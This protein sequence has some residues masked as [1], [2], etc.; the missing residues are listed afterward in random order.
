[1]LEKLKDYDQWIVWKMIDGRKVP[2]NP[3]NLKGAS[4]TSQRT[5]SSFNQALRVYQESED[6]EGVGFVFSPNDPFFGIDIDKCV[7]EGGDV[8]EVARVVLTKLSGTYG[9]WSPS[10]KGLHIIGE[11]RMPDW[12]H[13]KKDPL[14]LEIYD[15]NRY[16]TITFEQL[17]ECR[18]D[19]AEAQEELDLICTKYMMKER[20]Q[21]RD[22]RV[23]TDKLPVFQEGDRD[24]K[25]F[26]T[27]RSLFHRGMDK[28]QAYAVLTELARNCQPKFD[29]DEARRKVDSAWKT[30]DP[31]PMEVVRK[32][33]SK[34]A[35]IEQSAEILVEPESEEE[36]PNLLSM[37]ALRRL[38]SPYKIRYEDSQGRLRVKNEVDYWIEHPERRCHRKIVF[39]P[40]G[41]ENERDYNLWNGFAVKPKKGD[42]STFLKHVRE[43]VSQGDEQIA[44]W[45]LDWLAA[46]VQDPGGGPKTAVVLQGGQGVGKT[47]VGEYMRKIIGDKHFQRIAHHD[48]FVGRFNY[49]LVNNIFVHLDEA[50]W[51]GD[52]KSEGML[53][54]LITD[55]KVTVEM[56]GRDRF[57]IDNNVH[58]L[59]TSNEEWP[60]PMG[61]DDRR[62]MVINMGPRYKAAG[63]DFFSELFDE[64]NNRGGPEALLYYLRYERKLKDTDPE[65]PRDVG[66][67]HRDIK[68]ASLDDVGKV[69]M[70]WVTEGR[71]GARGEWVQVVPTTELYESY[72]REAR[73]MGFRTSRTSGS[74][75][76]R[77][78]HYLVGQVESRVAKSANS[79]RRACGI[80]IDESEE[81]PPEQVGEARKNSPS[82]RY[83]V[84]PSLE[85]V[86]KLLQVGYGL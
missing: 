51:G 40:N 43:N 58:L 13:K 8:N 9:E 42:C 31:H 77:L 45:L 64:M 2:L 36:M 75:K 34:Y 86:N 24:E 59:I 55:S 22:Q 15:K 26:D 79:I 78:N 68:E 41:L 4:S 1:M 44:E 35:I 5:W 12:A 46:I 30:E 47:V 63:K 6:L 48:H 66:P 28:W 29:E 83:T 70:N 49:D 76:K 17:Q 56:K 18:S 57:Q 53:K 74:F 54:S 25:L 21:Q 80:E 38:H 16:F 14:G 27:A 72:R 65:R 11:G 52:K 84:L 67:H 73:E 10:G 50:T 82:K 33:N 20:Y 61:E 71:V 23:G 39:K 3:R 81:E 85:E 19:V 32:L 60:V 69:L 37:D 62:F 7:N